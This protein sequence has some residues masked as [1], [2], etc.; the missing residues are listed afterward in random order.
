MLDPIRPAET[1]SPKAV[2]YLVIERFTVVNLVMEISPLYLLANCRINKC[3][4]LTVLPGLDTGVVTTA[5]NSTAATDLLNVT[6]PFRVVV[7]V[8]VAERNI[9]ELTLSQIGLI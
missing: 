6:A 5:A 3:L 9:A 8:G 4:R 1:I 7:R 2:P